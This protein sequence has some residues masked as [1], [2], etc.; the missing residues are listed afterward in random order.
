V[1]DVQRATGVRLNRVSI[2]GEEHRLPSTEPALPGAVGKLVVAVQGL[3]DLKYQ[4]YSARQLDP[5]SGKPMAPHPLSHVGPAE[6]FFNANCLHGSQTRDF[7]TGGGGPYAVY[8][9]TRYGIDIND[10]PPDLPYCGYTA[11]QV[12]KAYGITPLIKQKL[13][14]RNQTIAIVDAYG[15]DTIVGDADLFDQVN[16]LPQTSPIL[17]I[18]YPEGHTSCRKACIDGNWNIETTLDVEWAHSVAPGANIALLLSRDNSFTNLDLTVLYAIQNGIGPVISN[19]YGI[20]EVILETY[21]PSELTVENNLNELAASLGI[22]VNF[23]SGDDGDF[24]TVYG[25]TTVSMP[26]ASPYATG[27]G[28]TSLF[29]KSDHSI[30]M[31]TGWGNNETRIANVLPNPP[32]IPPLELG[33]IYGAGGGTSGVWAKPSYQGTLPGS[34]RLVPDIGFLADPYT[35]VEVVI[36]DPSSGEPVVEV[37]GGT[38]L[39]CPMF[40]ALWATTT[41]AAGVWL[42]QAAPVLYGLSSD[43]ITDVVAADGPDNISG[44]IHTPHNPPVFESPDSLAAPLG[45][46]TEYVSA[47]FNGASTRWYVLTFG[48]DTSLTTGPGWDNV[49]GLGT[50]NGANFVNAVVGTSK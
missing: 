4:N 30:K 9:G 3:A 43:A 15:S 50:P 18:Y 10:G 31:Q 24:S 42:G 21:L 13:D 16:G 20:G 34:W 14:G 40:S 36:T 25:I 28:G 49:T 5:D 44:V 48:T 6:Q 41:Q 38:S 45:N 47:F 39:A 26:A 22:S 27:V 2:N 35:G 29:L 12:D 8:S 33:F 17:N 32:I 46:T 23:S 1:D 11:P 37:I 7:F 19:S